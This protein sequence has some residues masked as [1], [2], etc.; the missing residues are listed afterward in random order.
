MKQHCNIPPGVHQGLSFAEYLAIDAVNHST[1]R[2]FARSAA[3]AHREITHPSEPTEAQDLGQAIHTAILEPGR[4][5][6]EFVVA[7]KVDRRTKEGKAEWAQFEAEHQGCTILK[8]EHWETCAG[9]LDAAWAHPT[10]SAILDGRGSNE[11]VVIWKDELTGIM[12]KARIDRLTTFAGATV[13]GDVKS[14]ADAQ[15]W[16]FARSAAKYGYHSQAA[17]YLDGLHTLAPMTRRFLTMAVEKPPPYC[18]AVYEYG[19]TS[20]EQG[21]QDYRKYLGQLAE[22]METGL[23]P[24]Y[25]VE[26]KEIEVPNWA[27]R[28]EEWE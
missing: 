16:A 26:I 4:F 28:P 13:I 27:I 6:K 18:A 12:C 3:H 14:T 5:R 7:P 21:R 17:F 9:M 24:G 15:E 20:I 2:L 22:S 23:W 11:V 8:Y 1:L 10:A 19:A 25:E